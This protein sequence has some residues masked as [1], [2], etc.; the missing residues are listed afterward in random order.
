MVLFASHSRFLVAPVWSTDI[1]QSA[2]LCNPAAMQMWLKFLLAFLVILVVM[3]V[4]FGVQILGWAKGIFEKG[5]KD[6]EDI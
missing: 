1:A 4:V 3:Q 6:A 2:P 5:K